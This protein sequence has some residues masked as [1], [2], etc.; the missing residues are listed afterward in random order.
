MGGIAERYEFCGSRYR[1]QGGR[2]RNILG[3]VTGN[4]REGT[5]ETG[6]IDCDA[7][8]GTC[9]I[10]DRALPTYLLPTPTDKRDYSSHISR[11]WAFT[12]LNVLRGLAVRGPPLQNQCQLLKYLTSIINTFAASYFL[13][14]QTQRDLF[15]RKILDE[16]KL[17]GK[18]GKI[19][20]SVDA[21]NKN[22]LKVYGKNEAFKKSETSKIDWKI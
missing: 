19:W 21:E 8:L 3:W 18:L 1:A 15:S 7:T 13:S 14:L 20:N 9:P 16:P 6:G 10:H 5:V 11:Y 2:R 4:G 17:P 22:K 12:R